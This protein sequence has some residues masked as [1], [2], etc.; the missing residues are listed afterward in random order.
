[1]ISAWA[2]QFYRGAGD[3]GAEAGQQAVRCTVA[4][5]GLSGHRDCAGVGQ[6]AEDARD[7]P[8]GYAAAAVLGQDADTA[9]PAVAG[10]GQRSPDPC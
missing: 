6:G 7:Q 4:F 9:Q 5:I 2:S 3:A 10:A 8:F 1:V